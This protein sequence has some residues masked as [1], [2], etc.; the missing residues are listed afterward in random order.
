MWIKLNHSEIKRLETFNSKNKKL[1]LLT[2]KVC[3]KYKMIKKLVLYREQFPFYNKEYCKSFLPAF[4]CTLCDYLEFES[5]FVSLFRNEVK[6]KFQNGEFENR[7]PV[8][9]SALQRFNSFHK[10]RY[11]KRK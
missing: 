9:A 6:N 5:E 10:D 1:V 4:S 11:G 3:H 7:I 2:C 8:K